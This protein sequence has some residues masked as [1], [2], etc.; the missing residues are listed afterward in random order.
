MRKKVL[1]V[2]AGAALMIVMAIGMQ[3]NNAQNESSL[4]LKNMEAL[5]ACYDIEDNSGFLYGQCCTTSSDDCVINSRG[6]I[7]GDFVW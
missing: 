1:K 3:M 4:K 5:A 6:Y 7:Y 2:V